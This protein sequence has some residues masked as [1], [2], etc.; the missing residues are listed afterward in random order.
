MSIKK[1]LSISLLALTLSACN[2]S[3]QLNDHRTGTIEAAQLLNQYPIFADAKQQNEQP[4]SDAEQTDRTLET[5]A[6]VAQLAKQ[7]HHKDIV[8]VF[9]TW[10]HDSQREVPRLLNLIEKVKRNHPEV[11]FTTTLHAVAPSE[12]RDQAIVNQYQLTYVPTIMLFSDGQEIGRI[13]ERSEKSLAL[14][15]IAM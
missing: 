13:I 3:G 10:C 5:D 11:E 7:L 15:M 8:V 2:S 1:L 9:G 14:D 12:Q 4:A 6:E